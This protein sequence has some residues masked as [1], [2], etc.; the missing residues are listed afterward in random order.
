MNVFFPWLAKPLQIVLT[1]KCVYVVG[2][3]FVPDIL[4]AFAVCCSC[5]SV[6]AGEAP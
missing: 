5:L 4:W 1:G 3:A 6:G 2:V